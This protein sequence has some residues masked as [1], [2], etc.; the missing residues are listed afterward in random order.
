MESDTEK[1][2]PS[3]YTDARIL[4]GNWNEENFTEEIVKYPSLKEKFRKF[5]LKR[6]SGNLISQKTA[7]IYANFLKEVQLEVPCDFVRFGAIIQLKAPDMPKIESISSTI[8]DQSLVVS[9]AVDGIKVN[10]IQRVNGNCIL[11]LAPSIRPCVRNTFIIT[12]P[13][14]VDRTNEI[15]KYNQDFNLKCVDADEM[16]CST[17]KVDS[18][19][20]S[21]TYSP[22]SFCKNGE[23]NQTVGL[24]VRKV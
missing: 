9:I 7:Q 22:Y 5:L 19:L 13:D 24:A 10:E 3:R 4:I 21:A 11:S 15:L 1:T 17:P 14:N 2:I 12:S 23:L 16:I 6:D 8:E 18:T 20:G